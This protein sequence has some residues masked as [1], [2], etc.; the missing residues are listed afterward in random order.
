VLLI[1]LRFVCLSDIIVIMPISRVSSSTVSSRLLT[2]L[3][4]LIAVAAQFD[5]AAADAGDVIA[6]LLGAAL[7]LVVICA[8]LGWYSRRSSGGGSGSSSSSSDS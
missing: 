3:F 5:T 1:E 2:F 8:F 4:A 6:G 7:A